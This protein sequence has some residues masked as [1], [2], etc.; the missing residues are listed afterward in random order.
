MDELLQLFSN[1]LNKAISG[2]NLCKIAEV[3]LRRG[4]KVRVFDGRQWV[5]VNYVVSESDILRI[6]DVATK[7]SA[8]SAEDEVRNGYLHYF[9]GVRI[10]LSGEG[11]TEN[12]KVVNLKNLSSVCVR[13]PTEAKGSGSEAAKRLLSGGEAK[14]GCLISPPG[15]GKTT[16]LR[17][18]VR[19]MSDSGLNVL[20]LDERY[21]L[22]APSE[23]ILGLDV[24]KNTDVVCGIQKIA[25][26]E[27]VVRSMNPD[28]VAVDEIYTEKE[29][30]ELA[31]VAKSGI[32]IL[33]TLHGSDF[34]RLDESDVRAVSCLTSVAVLL[35]KRP[36][37]GTVSDILE[38]A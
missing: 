5:Y 34:K 26:F 21:E 14:N 31:K 10:G 36:K 3:R 37:V 25:F 12:G 16:M 7:F 13:I 23:G 22:S 35:S 19:Q 29:A 1:D 4:Q 20:V 8:Y 18:V 6:T 32:K 24:G 30:N 15:C 9:G 38:R 28:V 33:Y 27:N 11:V 17:D 2:E